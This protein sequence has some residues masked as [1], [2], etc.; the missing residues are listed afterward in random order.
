MGAS[1]P[2]EQA[3]AVA[4]ESDARETSKTY[5]ASRLNGLF[6]GRIGPYLPI[7]RIW[8]RL[9]LGQRSIGANLTSGLESITWFPNRA[10][11]RRQITIRSSLLPAPPKVP[12]PS[13]L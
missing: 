5:T 10:L 2:T 6:A 4:F 9:T 11:L 1:V 3:D 13:L 12:P 8:R 7:I